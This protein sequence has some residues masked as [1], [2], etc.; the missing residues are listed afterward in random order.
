[1]RHRDL[2]VRVSFYL[3][4]SE[5]EKL[6]AI[7]VASLWPIFALLWL[8]L[9]NVSSPKRLRIQDIV[10]IAL[11]FAGAALITADRSGFSL[12]AV[13]IKV[14][15]L[16]GLAAVAG[17]FWEP[18]INKIIQLARAPSGNSPTVVG[19]D[20]LG[21]VDLTVL[22]VTAARLIILP[23]YGITL[24]LLPHGPIS[25]LTLNFLLVAAA[26]TLFGYVISDILSTIAFARSESANIV[27]VTYLVPVVA[28]LFFKIAY[29]TEISVVTL[30][31]DCTLFSCRTFS[32]T[33][34]VRNSLRLRLQSSYS[35]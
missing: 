18:S 28:T 3:A 29:G 1:M 20:Q 30:S 8:Q 14:V 4:L 21:P 16:A 31:S 10:F 34:R 9:L 17:G 13:S 25:S 19:S 26:I 23:L 5:P 27:S 35:C 33:L 15:L 24:L 6:L 11:A 7:I 12:G 32:F 2:P 22:S